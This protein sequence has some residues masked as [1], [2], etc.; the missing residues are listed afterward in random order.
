M[1][2]HSQRRCTRLSA[3]ILGDRCVRWRQ[4]WGTMA[5]AVGHLGHD[6]STD[7]VGL[8]WVVS[9]VLIC[10][11][12]Y[13]TIDDAYLIRW[14]WASP[15][16]LEPL[17][18]QP[19]CQIGCYAVS[20]RKGHR[21]GKMHGSGGGMID[22]NWRWRSSSSYGRHGAPLSDFKHTTISKH[23]MEEFYIIKTRK[24]YH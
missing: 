22:I 18:W 15:P 17:A 14:W 11:V 10:R 16:A 24:N 9:Y 8:L 2:P 6:V 12:T 3:N 21:G 4:E 20:S 13:H 7:V 5:A 19:L 1:V 23:T